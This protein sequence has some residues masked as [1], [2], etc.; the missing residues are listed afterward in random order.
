MI[1]EPSNQMKE[2]TPNAPTLR[3][4]LKKDM[5]YENRQEF[6]ECP[7]PDKS[8]QSWIH[9]IYKRDGSLKKFDK[10]MAQVLEKNK[11]RKLE[12]IASERPFEYRFKF[13]GSTRVHEF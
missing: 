13:E 6:Y 7:F 8:I 12:A 2:E 3:Q 5:K 4:E 1:E 9:F 11:G 10:C